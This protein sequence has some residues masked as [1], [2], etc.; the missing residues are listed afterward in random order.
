M[1]KIYKDDSTDFP[2]GNTPEEAI[3]VGKNRK[4]AYRVVK[5]AWLGHED[6][7]K[8]YSNIKIRA[9][10]EGSFDLVNGEHG[11][12][13]KLYSG[14]LIPSEYLWDRI[15]PGNELQIAH[16]GTDGQADLNFRPLYIHL[17][18]PSDAK[19]GTHYFE[20]VIEALEKA[21]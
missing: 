9:T 14:N 19:L 16:I 2:V 5:K 21:V 4:S 3:I 11:Y 17:E 15:I 13:V 18:T 12:S 1:L 10:S 20:I 8:W 6:D 7:T